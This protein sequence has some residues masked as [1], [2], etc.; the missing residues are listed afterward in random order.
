MKKS[1]T[2]YI[3]RTYSFKDHSHR[4]LFGAAPIEPIIPLGRDVSE[5]PV[6]YQGITQG[7]VPATIT[8][9]KSCLEESH[10]DLCWEWLANI[11]R[12]ASDGS[13][14]GDVLE[15][16]RK[17]GIAL[18]EKGTDAEKHRIGSYYYV[19]CNPR[20]IYAALKKSVL[21][22]GVNDPR[23]GGLHFLGAFDVTE[24][25]KLKCRNSQFPSSPQN[26]VEVDLNYV[27]ECI[28]F[29]GELVPSPASARFPVYEVLWDKV[30]SYPLRS[31]V[32]GF[33]TVL[34]V[35]FP[36]L[37][38]FG[39]AGVY[40]KFAPTIA[41]SGM[42][43]TDASVPLSSFTLS[44][45]TTVATSTIRFP[46]YWVINP[47]STTDREKVEC[48]GLDLTNTK[49]IKCYR[50]ISCNNLTNSTS[51]ISGGAYAHP[52][53][54]QVIMSNDNCFYNRFVDIDTDQS[55][56]SG[57][58]TFI[59]GNTGGQINIGN[60]AS[61]TGAKF[62]YFKD[63][64]TN[65][66]YFKVVGPSGINSTS[67]FY[68]SPDGVSDLLLNTSG[69]TFGVSSTAGLFLTNGL[70]GINASTSQA[71][72]F[73]SNNLT[74]VDVSSTASSNGGFLKIENS[75]R[76]IYWDISSFLSGAW[77]WT[78]LQTFGGGIAVTV[79]STYSGGTSS[80]NDLVNKSYVDLGDQ[81]NT[82]TGTTGVA[83][84][85][86]QAI[87]IGGDGN[88]YHTNAN[89]TNT[90]YEFV[91]IALTTSTASGQTITYVKPGGIANVNIPNFGTAIAQ[92][93]F[94]SDS[95]GSY[96]ANTK[97]TITARIGLTLNA[98]SF[99]V[100]T[101]KFYDRVTGISDPFAAGTP[102]TITTTW[103]PTRIDLVCG[104]TQ[105]GSSGYWVKNS[106][107]TAS[108]ASTGW[109]NVSGNLVATSTRACAWQETGP[110][111]FYIT[112][113]TTSNGFTLTPN[114]GGSGGRTVQYTA[115]TNED[116]TPH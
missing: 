73:D 112:V 80:T 74:Y 9:I 56:V 65:S 82:A 114:V 29:G 48:N 20:E 31:A 83:I 104:L 113:A 7:C 8:F 45:G 89:A 18:D 87:R 47:N 55:S 99:L 92:P 16:A 10:P 115:E 30:S 95:N 71:L 33:L 64:Q 3:Y 44:D 4:R 17:I 5:V 105:T 107:G 86:G 78:G 106:N 22:I 38:K 110:N 19:D 32:A 68:F 34:S 2:G 97:G 76:K 54:E 58:K 116:Y 91:G 72:K 1:K 101:P 50:A 60:N 90:V 14:P 49:L 94:L 28:G 24:D 6:Q 98:N 46:S 25:G 61:T 43:S 39:S 75:L 96:A 77:S 81:H 13:Y 111:Y 84:N 79:T 59:G 42:S 62:I 63:G 57:T 85:A 109:Y 53:G 102:Q 69:T 37:P 66:P 88:L 67:S 36:S 15:A 100:M 108:Q 12:T 27:I 41:G 51:T 103:S 11:G 23:F 70:L 93:V 52:A 26:E 40:D 21:A 35:A